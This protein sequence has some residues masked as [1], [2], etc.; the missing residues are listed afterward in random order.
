MGTPSYPYVITDGL[1]TSQNSDLAETIAKRGSVCYTR[2][3]PDSNAFDSLRLDASRTVTINGELLKINDEL[4]TEEINSKLNSLLESN[5]TPENIEKLKSHYS[6]R[7]AGI[8]IAAFADHMRNSDATW[9]P[10]LKNLKA[11][12]YEKKGIAYLTTT[13]DSFLIA[14]KDDP[15][16]VVGSIQGPVEATFMLT[17]KGFELQSIATHSLLLHDMYLGHVSEERIL[18]NCLIPEIESALKDQLYNLMLEPIDQK[19]AQSTQSNVELVSLQ[20]ALDQLK[21][22]KENKITLEDIQGAFTGL[23]K[24]IDAS[25]SLSFKAVL[26]IRRLS[27][28]FYTSTDSVTTTSILTQ[29]LKKLQ[30]TSHMVPSARHTPSGPAA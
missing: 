27:T 19:K 26:G 11:D 18:G 30:S 28:F 17:D 16:V 12:L 14:K 24:E 15:Q 1:K 8:G 3:T 10:R 21:N 4:T 13:V 23:I 6:Q 29:S 2:D 5:F 20:K 22:Y 25:K 9:T 7:P